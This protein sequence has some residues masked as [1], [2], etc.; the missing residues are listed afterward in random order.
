MRD[1]LLGELLG[2]APDS[3]WPARLRPAIGLPGF[4]AELRE[5]LLRAAERGLGP[6]R[7]DRAGAAPRH[8]GVGGRRPVLPHLRARDPA[9]RGGRPRR[10]A[11]HRARAGRRRA[12]V[13][14]AGRAGLRPGAAG[15]RT[16]AG[17]P[18][19]GRRRPGPRPAAAGAGPR[20]RVHRRGRCCWPATRTRPCSTSAAPTRTG[21][22]RSTPRRSCSAPT[23]GARPPSAP[24]A[25]GWPPGC[26]GAGPGRERA[27]ARAG[28]PR[29]AD[30]GTV[31]VRIFSSPAQEAGWVADQLRRAHLGAGV[32][33]SGMAVLVRSTRRTLPA[34]RRALLAAGVPI[35]A[36]PDELPLARQPAVVPLLMVLRFAARPRELD[37]DAAT[38]LLTS[39]L[40]SAD[41]MRMRRL[42][43][44]LLRLHA[45]AAPGASAAAEADAR[46]GDRVGTGQQRPAAGRGAARGRSR[47]SRTRWPSCRPRRPR[48]CAGSVRLLG[49][50][51]RRDPGRAR[52]PRRCSG[53]SGRPPGWVRGGARPAPAA[54]RSARPPT[55][56][57]TPCSRCSRPRPSTP[58]GC[59]A[60]TSPASPTTSPTSSCPATRWPRGPRRARRC[61]CSPRTP[62]AAAS[63]TWSPCPRCRKGSWP[64][65]RLRGSLLGN[66]RLVDLV[67]GTADPGRGAGLAVGA[68]A[69]RGA[70]AVL[71]G[72]H[73]GPAHPA[74]QR[75]GR[76][77]RAAL[78]LPRRAGPDAGRPGRPAG[79][80]A[81]AGRWCWPSWSAS[82]VGR[83]ASR[84]RPTSRRPSAPPAGERRHGP[85]PSWPGWPT[86]ACRAP[87]PTTG[88]AWPRCP[89]TPR[90]APPARWCRSRRR[91]WRRSPGARCAGCWSG[92]AAASSAR[93]PRSPA[94]WCTRWCRPARPARTA[95][96]WR[97]RCARPGRGWTPGPPGSGAA[98]SGRVRGMLAAFDGW[99]RSSRAE[100]LR[101]V[102][103]EQPVRLDLPGGELER[104]AGG[105]QLRGRVDRLEVDA[106]GRPVVVDVKTG[107]VALSSRAAAEHPQLA[108]YQ[109][110]AALGAFGRLLEPGAPPGGA[111]LV[112]L[113]DQKAGGQVK[114][115]AQ[116][117]AG[118]G[119][120]GPLGGGVAAVRPGVVG[121]DVRGP[122]RAGL[123]PLPGPRQLPD[124][125]G[126]PPRTR[127]LVEERPVQLTPQELADAL[128]LPPPTDE[129]AAVIA[130]PARPRWWWPG[131]A[132]ARPRRWPPGWSGWWPPA[133]CCPEQVLGLTFTRKAAQQLGA[134]VRSRLRR[135]AGSR[136]LDELDPTGRRRADLAAGE[137]TISTY[138]AYAGRLVGEHA[139]LLPAEP[140]ARL[141]GQTAAWQLAHRVVTS[142]ADE[143]EVDVVP[144]TVTGWLLALA[145]ELGE[146]LVEPAACPRTGRADDRR[147][148][149]G[150]ARQGA[151]GRAVPDLP[152]LDRRAAAA[153]R[154]VAAGRGVLGAQAGGARGRLHRPAGH[155]RPGRR[156]APG[157]RR[158]R[159]GQLPVGAARRVP[160]HRPRPA[161]AAARAVRHRAGRPGAAR[162]TR[163][164]PRSATPASRSTAGA[165]RARATCCAS[166]PTSRPRTA[167]PTPT[168]C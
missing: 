38:A 24:P 103:V 141:L 102:A 130:A 82:C 160:G 124:P 125:R 59:P 99:V 145:G 114:E 136:L 77:G 110:A 91:T 159:A 66:E 45:P 32:P 36:P 151:A 131:P 40:G 154:A 52:A 19:G 1:L 14:G 72:L 112:Y 78:A 115:P 15:R 67:A 168:A 129:Q 85:P 5:L 109:L 135:L 8:A 94:R 93:W 65:L 153:R 34:L 90:C 108:I 12:G 163:R 116:P 84:T 11:G 162:T 4:A 46:A 80:P 86:P 48:R 33:W 79:A 126:R 50:G 165:G 27:A 152:A 60:P 70:P 51:R 22:G 148:V 105:L 62:R 9:A 158:G 127:D 20:A 54:A 142:W 69:G 75:G 10:A 47:S 29:R 138:H 156:A 143:L 146:H 106:D 144:A 92:T 88:T 87:T 128:G 147:A 83:C 55:A 122:G 101:L 167:R 155:R 49:A 149:G 3:G 134:R 43:R 157:G 21:C 120:A 150:A 95:P 123:R 61:R 23:T 16:A 117:P 119:R 98:S 56:T 6:G 41:P 68:A 37:A 2:E 81:R 133:R 71:R 161:G 113:A 89:P 28:T 35:A 104:A 18:P 140:A 30:G 26:P 73:P 132:P 64:D 137:P 53:G 63:G 42:R 118:R 100:G 39:P 164:S 97:G 121:L 57:S 96:S 166:A 7:A 76:G 25:P 111:R 31:A 13:R 17:A 107:K 74:G 58:T 44:G 139:L